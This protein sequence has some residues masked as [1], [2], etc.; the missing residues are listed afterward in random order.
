MEIDNRAMMNELGGA[1]MV[2]WLVLVKSRRLLRL[3][4]LRTLTHL[5]PQPVLL[6]LFPQPVLLTLFPQP[7]HPFYNWY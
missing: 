1:F 2:S 7:N 5:F 4:S 6:T 3:G